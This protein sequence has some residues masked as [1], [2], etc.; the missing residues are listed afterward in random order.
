MALTVSGYVTLWAEKGSD[1][2][3][4]VRESAAG[5]KVAYIQATSSGKKRETGEWQ[6]DWRG[7]LLFS[8]E[9]YDKIIELGVKRCD[10]LR[11]NKGM[12]TSWYDRET[13][14]QY[15]N[16]LIQDFELER[17][18][19]EKPNVGGGQTAPTVIISDNPSTMAI[20]DEDFPF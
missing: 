1:E 12:E 17:H 6:T 14:K 5:K 2:V 7:T 19:E 9:A 15:N 11:I 4:K 13:K 8:G 10:R 16:Y 18:R 3:V 20:K